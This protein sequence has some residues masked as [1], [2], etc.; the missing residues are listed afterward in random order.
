MAPPLFKGRSLENEFQ[1][2]ICELD[3]EAVRHQQTSTRTSTFA[4]EHKLE[5][6]GTQ[7]KVPKAERAAF[8][9]TVHSLS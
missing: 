3:V 2:S 5:V 4:K 9:M 1:D 7:D 6:V 8:Q